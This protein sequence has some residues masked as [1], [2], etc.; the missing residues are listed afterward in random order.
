MVDDPFKR[1]DCKIWWGVL[2]EARLVY[3]AV[4]DVR[5]RTGGPSFSVIVISFDEIWVGVV[6]VVSQ[7]ARRRHVWV[8]KERGERCGRSIFFV[9]MTVLFLCWQRR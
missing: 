5:V 3:E 2:D 9:R 1:D 8:N 4:E 7:A 6:S